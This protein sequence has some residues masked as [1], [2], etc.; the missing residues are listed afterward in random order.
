MEL[1]AIIQS[2]RDGTL[3]DVEALYLLMVQLPTSPA[4]DATIEIVGKMY[5]EEVAEWPVPDD[6]EAATVEDSFEPNR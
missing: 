2:W 5:Q 4:T 3:S 6:E 1:D